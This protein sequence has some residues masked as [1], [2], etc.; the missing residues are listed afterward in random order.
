MC[1]RFAAPGEDEIVEAFGV[2]DVSGHVGPSWNLAP[3]QMVGIVIERTRDDKVLRQLR[4]ARWGLV[5]SWVKTFDKRSVMFNARAETVMSKPSFASAALRR[6]AL[7][8]AWGY[9]E[10]EKHPDG[11]STPYFLHPYDDSVLGLAGLYEWWRVPAGTTVNGAVD[12]WLCSVTIMTH[13]AADELGHIH[14][15]MPV[16]VSEGFVDDWLD[17]D[18]TD[19]DD[20][21]QMISAMPDP[22]LTPTP[23]S[24]AS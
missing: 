17:P 22:A 9:Y 13:P 3:S 8:P 11:S 14:D 4:T 21:E 10:W 16:V 20:V 6:R 7:V 2:Q 23:R 19:R 15:R 5:P 24:P 1:G 12:G 18:L